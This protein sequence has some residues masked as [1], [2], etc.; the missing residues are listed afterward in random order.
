MK[1]DKYTQ[2]SNLLA[3]YLHPNHKQ[4]VL[5][6]YG[7]NIEKWAHNTKRYTVK[8][9]LWDLYKIPD[10]MGH[11]SIKEIVKQ[12]LH[13][14][15]INDNVDYNYLEVMEEIEQ[16]NLQYCSMCRENLPLNYFGAYKTCNYCREM[17]H[18]KR[19]FN[20]MISAVEGYIEFR[21]SNPDD[22]PE[23]IKYPCIIN[24]HLH[25]R[26]IEDYIEILTNDNR[27]LIF[28]LIQHSNEKYIYL[29]SYNG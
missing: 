29:I 28:E 27:G 23:N 11:K 25:F 9:L 10:V 4:I 13:D 16:N 1:F 7:D 3:H 22:E 2:A 12:Y 20:K 15:W 8:Y 19:V 24:S 5:A 18:R 6:F 21:N 14:E 26:I 17:A